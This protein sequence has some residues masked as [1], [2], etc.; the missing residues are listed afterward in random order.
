MNLSQNAVFS[1]FLTKRLW[2]INNKEASVT[3]KTY[4]KPVNKKNK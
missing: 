1:R 2:K 4:S 3:H